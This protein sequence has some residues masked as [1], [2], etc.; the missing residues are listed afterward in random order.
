MVG[1]VEPFLGHIVKLR[2]PVRWWRGCNF[3]RRDGRYCPFFS[4]RSCHGSPPPDRSVVGSFPT[5]IS[6]GEHLNREIVGRWFSSVSRQFEKGASG[7]KTERLISSLSPPRLDP[8]CCLVFRGYWPKPLLGEPV[9]LL[10]SHTD[11]PSDFDCGKAT[12]VPPPVHSRQ[13]AAKRRSKFLQ[14]D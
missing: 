14:R 1:L 12:F 10:F 8:T 3:G 11:Q 13:G 5:K 4:L 2:E 6:L 9:G 7:L